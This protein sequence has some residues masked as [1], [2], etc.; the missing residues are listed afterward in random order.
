MPPRGAEKLRLGVSPLNRYRRAAA[1]APNDFEAQLSVAIT[2]GKMLPLMAI[3]QQLEASSHI[4]AFADKAVRLNPQSDLA[5]HVLGRWH[6]VL[7][8]VTH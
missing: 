8:D 2:Y 7:S 6:R 3:R 5:W 4:R 1:L